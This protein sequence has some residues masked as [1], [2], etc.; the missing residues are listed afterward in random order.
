METGGY[1]YIMTNRNNTVLYIGVT[2]DLARRKTEHASGRGSV[3]TN[4]Y[5]CTKLVYFEHCPD[6]N[7]AIQREKQLKNWKR[8]WKI[9]L[10]EKVNPDWDD[11]EFCR[12]S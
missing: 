9:A 6:I 11:L 7:Q 5:N 10:I 2:A 4:K 8:A 12:F 3:F 1:I